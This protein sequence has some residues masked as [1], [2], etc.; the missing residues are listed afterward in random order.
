MPYHRFRS[1][2]HPHKVGTHTSARYT[3]DGATSGK[4]ASGAVS[5]LV[6][7][8]FMALLAPMAAS[9][10]ARAHDLILTGGDFG[11]GYTLPLSSLT[12]LLG[13]LAIGLWSA[14][15]GG[16]AVWQLPVI[17]LGS[18]VFGELIGEVGV[19]VPHTEQ[20][21]MAALVVIGALMVLGL[22]LPLVN[23]WGVVALI[24]LFE[25]YPLAEAMHH[26]SQMGC[27]V[28]YGAGALLAMAGGL[29]F[30]VMVANPI[31]VRIF[32]VAIAMGGVAMLLDKI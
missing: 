24:A 7:L 20:A 18:A 23:P 25:G 15:L 22:R 31:G 6:G 32:G 5:S 21:L 14:Q 13:F 2:G 9:G 10:T 16:A 4:A 12:G 30:V 3:C 19:I 8:A 27:W 17:A 29:G 11:T 26:G 28:G 1:T